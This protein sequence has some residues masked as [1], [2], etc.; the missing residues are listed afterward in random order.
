M[1]K[2]KINDIVVVVKNNSINYWV[3]E[4]YKNLSRACKINTVTK[5]TR[6]VHNFSYSGND[7]TKRNSVNI[8]ILN[9]TR[10]IRFLVN[11]LRLA[12]QREQFLYYILG[13]HVLGETE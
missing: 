4:E 10:D 2:F 9:S 12:T 13:P 7:F 6:I 8:K 5:V 3:T 11:D 1:N